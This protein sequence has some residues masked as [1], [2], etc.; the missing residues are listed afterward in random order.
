MIMAMN[1]VENVGKESH[2][3]DLT[4]DDDL[5]ICLDGDKPILDPPPVRAK[6]VTNKRI[7]GPLEKGKKKKVKGATTSQVPQASSMMHG[8]FSSI[9]SN[10][11]FLV[12]SINFNFVSIPLCLGEFATLF[13][14]LEMCCD[15]LMVSATRI[16]QESF[17][18][19]QLNQVLSITKVHYILLFIIIFLIMIFFYMEL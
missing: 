14:P 1:K 8:N 12:L 4:N 13:F 16:F 5:K 7:K 17:F 3:E 15:Y 10:I 19:P 18:L 2:Q 9:N 11:V 6:G